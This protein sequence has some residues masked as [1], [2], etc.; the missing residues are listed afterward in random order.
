MLTISNKCITIGLTHLCGLRT[1]E[2]VWIAF[3]GNSFALS[4]VLISLADFHNSY[5]VIHLV[6]SIQ[7]SLLT[8]AVYF[9]FCYFSKGSVWIGFRIERLLD[10]DVKHVEEKTIL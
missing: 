6:G 1:V 8:D 3:M 9:M 7:N 5:H 10:Q 4:Y 2:L